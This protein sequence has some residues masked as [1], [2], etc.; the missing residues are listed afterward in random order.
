VLWTPGYWGW[1]E[2]FYVWYPGYWG[3]HVGFYGGINY[4]FGYTGVGFVGGAWRGGV[5]TYNRAV[6]N[7]N[8]TNTTII[9]NTYNNT[10][11]INNNRTMINNHTSFSGGPGGV[12][13]RPTGVEQAAAR[14]H[15]ISPTAMQTQHQQTAGN[16]RQLLASVNHGSPSI[17]ASPRAGVFSGQG[18]TTANRGGKFDRPAGNNNV[19]HG[20]GNNA[21]N[22]ANNTGNTSNRSM[23]TMSGNGPKNGMRSDRPSNAMNAGGPGRGMRGNSP[24]FRASNANSGGSYG[25]PNNSHAKNVYPGENSHAGNVYANNSHARVQEHQEH[26]NAP[27]PDKN[28]NRGGGRDEKEHR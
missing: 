14:E 13:A 23:N 12:A 25:N 15:H 24:D 27:H 8:T 10:T 26:H 17:A 22:S 5:Y 7:V 16:N 20:G 6:T 28:Q 9:N 19:A 11:V 18:V 1:R 2:G 3:P 21:T 4:G